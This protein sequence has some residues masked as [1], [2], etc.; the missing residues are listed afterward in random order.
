MD[1]IGVAEGG[2]YILLWKTIPLL[3][4]QQLIATTGTRAFPSFVI[5]TNRR[6]LESSG[7]DRRCIGVESFPWIQHKC[8]VHFKDAPIDGCD[9]I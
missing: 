4:I 8:Q 9:G 6:V 1:F 7:V 5:E 2:L 3:F